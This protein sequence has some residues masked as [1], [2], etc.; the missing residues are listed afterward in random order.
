MTHPLSQNK[1]KTL[2][3]KRFKV[4]TAPALYKQI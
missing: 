2:A 4:G 3:N 1:Q